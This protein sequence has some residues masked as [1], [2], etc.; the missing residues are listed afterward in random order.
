MTNE[1]SGPP[2]CWIRQESTS[3][4]LNGRKTTQNDPPVQTGEKFTKEFVQDRV[5]GRRIPAIID[6][7]QKHE[8]IVPTVNDAAWNHEKRASAVAGM[9]QNHE[10]RVGFDG[11]QSYQLGYED[12][13]RILGLRRVDSECA[14]E[15]SDFVSAK[16][17]LRESEVEAYADKSSRYHNKGGD[18]GH[19]SRKAFSELNCDMAGLGPTALSVYK[20]GKMKFLCSFGGKILPRPSDG[21]LR[22][23]GG[24]TRIISIRKN[25]SWDELVKKT[26]SICNQPHAIKYQLPDEDLDALISVSSDEDLQNMIEEYHGLEKND[27]SQRLR[28]FLV[29]SGESENTPS[30]DA[31][32]MQQDNP[33]YQY[34]AAVNGMVDP[35]PRKDTAEQN[36]ASEASQLETKTSAFPLEIKSNFIAINPTQFSESQ[37]IN[38]S[39]NQS[40]LVPLVLKQYGDSKNFHVQSHGDNSC[41]GSYESNSSFVTSQLQPEN[42]CYIHTPTST[43]TATNYHYHHP[44]KQ[45]DV[46]LPDQSYGGNFNDLNCNRE[47]LNPWVIDQND[48]DFGGFSLERPVQKERTFHSEKPGSRL[49]DPM[50]LLSQ[51]NDAADSH[52]GIPH[53]FSDS[54]LQESG[55]KSAYC[56]QEGMSPSSPL[57]FAKAQ[58]SLP[59]NSG[60]SQEKPTKQCENIDFVN[61]PILD[62]QSVEVHGR[63]D[64]LNSPCFDAVCRKEATHKVID[65]IEYRFQTSE[66]CITKSNFSVSNTCEKDPLTSENMKRI[67]VIDSLLD[68]DGKNY[69]GNSVVTEGYKGK[70]PNINLNPFANSSGDKFPVSAAIGF[71]PLVDNLMEHPKNYQCEESVPDLLAVSQ[72]PAKDK[73]CALTGKLVGEHRIDVPGTTDSE[74]AGLYPTARRRSHSENFVSDLMS[75]LSNAP[76]V[77]EPAQLQPIAREMAHREPLPVSSVNLC[78]LPAQGDPCTNS[79]LEKIDEPLLQN[80]TQDAAFK[81]EVSLLD[82]DFVN[83]PIPKDEKIGYG[84]SSYTESHVEKNQLDS[85]V[86]VED[87]TN[88]VLPGNQTSS[89][90]TPFVVDESIGYAISPTATEVESIVQESE[91]EVKFVEIFLSFLCFESHTFFSVF[92]VAF[93]HR[94]VRHMM[95]TTDHL[96]MQ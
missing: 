9:A 57:N 79:N 56:S 43:V 77:H 49:E 8:K 52:R 53:A 48:G 46:G 3:S 76:F 7:A 93:V 68:Q 18:G 91:S 21:K 36:L 37:N 25:I 73:D 82:D 19:G 55:V 50:G 35:S 71:N 10:M 75:G 63:L 16:G 58:L 13:A 20:S 70:L 84:K 28:I 44:Y 66:N 17:S 89:T 40:S 54:K 78:S 5:S 83:H 6:M 85:V 90:G 95:G 2:V 94:T 65:D 61:P 72:Q 33:N 81:S 22:Y 14:S 62:N 38:G 47:F 29:P 86:V 67:D 26:T 88:V 96:V 74:M 64:L 1:V 41:Q 31:S 23:V 69:G 39:Q 27:G 12:L 4:V 59:L 87:V 30:F 51:S 60:A 24:E 15:A 34:V 92:I 80:P 45:A 42:S 32:T 11:N